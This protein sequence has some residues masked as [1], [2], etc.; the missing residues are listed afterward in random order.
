MGIAF[1]VTAIRVAPPLPDLAAG[2]LLPRLPSGAA[3]LALGLVGT[4]V[5]PY[6]LFLGSGLAHG[7]SMRQM[8]FG[9][10]VAV[11]LG[12]LISMAVVV[13]GTTMSACF[14]VAVQNGSW[15]ISVSR[16]RNARRR[17]FRS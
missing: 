7:Q 17:R 5:V 12:G 8:R 16:R 3:M 15:T 6:N 4:T 1:V 2:L 10:G 11:V 9:L 14:A 13:V